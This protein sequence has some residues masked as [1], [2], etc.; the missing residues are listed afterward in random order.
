VG[1]AGSGKSARASPRLSC[2]ALNTL[3]VIDV[4]VGVRVSESQTSAAMAR[5]ASSYTLGSICGPATAGVV[6]NLVP[7]HG[8][9]I[10]AA[11]G[12]YLV[13]TVSWVST[14]WAVR[15]GAPSP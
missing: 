4:D 6:M 5:N 2:F 11:A 7:G 3:A 15:P 13:A 8:L 14:R 12:A 10:T 9:M 1:V